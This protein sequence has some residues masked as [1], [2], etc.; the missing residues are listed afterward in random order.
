MASRAMNSKSA[1]T[2]PARGKADWRATFRRSAHRALQVTGAI[3]LFSL[4]IF[5]TLSLVSYT[6]TDPSPSTA[7]SGDDVR[8]WMGMTGAWAADRV[9]FLFGIP[10]ILLLPL[11]YIS[12]RKLWRNVEDSEE[13]HEEMRWW[14][15]TGLLLLSIFLLGTVLS[16]AF[17]GPG[18][19][20]PAQMGGISGLLGAGA[21]EAIAS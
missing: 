13:V 6:Q 8:N 5:L 4:L 3:A 11:I 2:S 10:A 15:P 17:E 12:A 14:L 21:I 1:N 19:T 20:L 9:L 7:A 16:L 18:G